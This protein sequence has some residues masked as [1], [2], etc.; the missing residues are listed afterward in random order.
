LTRDHER[1]E[2]VDH[3]VELLAHVEAPGLMLQQGGGLVPLVIRQE[4]TSCSGA[5]IKIEEGQIRLTFSN[6][7]MAKVALGRIA[8][9]SEVMSGLTNAAAND[10]EDTLV[11]NQEEIADE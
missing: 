9:I 11:L 5:I 1:S 6:S 4:W 2:H 10:R 7:V 3:N 8:L